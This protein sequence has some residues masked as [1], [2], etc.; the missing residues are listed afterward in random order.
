MTGYDVTED[1]KTVALVFS[2]ASHLPGLWHGALNPFGAAPTPTVNPQAASWQLGETRA[3]VWTSRDGW[4]VEGLLTLPV[5]YEPGRRYPLLVMLHGGPEAAVTL[6]LDPGY[7]E[8]PQVW[9][10]RGWAVLQPNYRGGSNYGDRFL[11]GM[12]GDTGGGDF[13]DIMTG[14][15]AV[16][17]SGIADPDRMAV[18]GWSWGGIS[19]GWIITQTDRFKVASAGAMVANHFSVFGEADLTYDV[20]HFYVGGTPWADPAKYIRMSPIGHVMQAKTPTLLLHGMEDIRCPT[21]QS[22]EFYRGLQAAGV[23]TELVLYPR[24]PH[25]FREPAHQ[26]D[27][28]R[29]EIAWIERHVAGSP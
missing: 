4:E 3:S 15:D 19:T 12:N 26:L 27:K 28:M 11:Q 25:V 17:A 8:Y 23:E 22:T 24:E 2:D 1:G 16:V 14:V 9:A 10:G 18:M 5:G 6:A 7:I 13:E 20:E 21:P 29:R